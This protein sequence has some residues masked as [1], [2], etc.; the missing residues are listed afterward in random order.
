MRP[1]YLFIIR[2]LPGSG[3]ST[4]GEKIAQSFR[5]ICVAADDYFTDNAGG[6]QFEPSKIARAHQWCRDTVREAML[7]EAEF[8]GEW[9]AV[10]VAN[11]FTRH[12]EM[13][14][15]L[16]LAEE[17]GWTPIVVTMPLP[18]NEED[19]KVLYERQIHG[20]PWDT[21]VQMWNRWED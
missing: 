15:Y 16:D 17:F 3:K 6:Y 20:V 13:E 11:T 21:M 12:W 5:T 9:D 2:G 14:P 8:P 1:R 10:A 7:H 4:L 18:E 19:L